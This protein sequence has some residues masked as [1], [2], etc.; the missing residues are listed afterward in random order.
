MPNRHAVCIGCGCTDL[1]ACEGGCS[2]LAVDRGKGIG[3]CSR[4]AQNRQH[5]V[6]VLAHHAAVNPRRRLKTQLMQDHGITTGRQLK[7]LRR[8]LR[9]EERKRN[10]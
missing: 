9:H 3:V 6:N 10:A 1:R 4:C 8:R 2:W 7:K 5:A